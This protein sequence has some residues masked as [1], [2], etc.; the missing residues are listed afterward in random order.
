[1]VAV[2]AATLFGGRSH[3]RIVNIQDHRESLRTDN[4]VDEQVLALEQMKK[5]SKVTFNDATI[6]KLS[7]AHVNTDVI[8][9]LISNS[10]ADYDLSAN[11]IIN[12]QISQLDPSI[13]LAMIDAG[14][15]FTEQP[16]LSAKTRFLSW[17]L[18]AE[19]GRDTP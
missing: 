8:L 19:S 2:V 12:L 17:P 15:S 13:I 16:A 1:M 3:G 9:K 6:I 5:R 4:V 14:Y 10:N 11:S 18:K 7:K